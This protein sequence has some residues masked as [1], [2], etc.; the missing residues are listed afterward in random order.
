MVGD[1][2]YAMMQRVKQTFD[3]DNLFNPD[4]IIGTPPMDTSLRHTPGH[5]DPQHETLLD[6]SGSDGVLAA[7]EKCT[8]VGECRKSHL[9]GGTMCPSYMAT[10]K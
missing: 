6:F 8:G 4:K 7:T 10:R 1:E 3:P 2:C 9:M 5:A